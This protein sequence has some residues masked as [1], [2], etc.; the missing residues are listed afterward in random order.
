MFDLVNFLQDSTVTVPAI[1]SGSDLILYLITLAAGAASAW[2]VA[3]LAKVN[4][5]VAKLNE[6]VKLGAYAVLSYSVLKLATL[7]GMSLPENPLAW[8]P[9]TVNTVLATLFAW[10]AAKMGVK[11]P[12]A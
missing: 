7:L 8:D 5:F 11:K 10:V 3:A 12:V 2:V 1:T 9:T 6:Y 4:E